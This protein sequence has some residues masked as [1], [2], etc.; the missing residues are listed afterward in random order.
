MITERRLG[1]E[2]LR[3]E[4]HFYHYRPI[5]EDEEKEVEVQLDIGTCREGAATRSE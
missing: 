5:D 4:I 2:M 3:D 1:K